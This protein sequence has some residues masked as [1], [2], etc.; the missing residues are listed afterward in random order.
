MSLPCSM[1]CKSCS[2]WKRVALH[3]C[4]CES[5]L[6][7]YRGVK[8]SPKRGTA[9]YSLSIRSNAG[10]NLDVCIE[11]NISNHETNQATMHDN[12]TSESKKTHPS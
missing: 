3:I 1:T 7:H 2:S 12:D 11:G 8:I 6:K 5:Y 9:I 4:Q 10:R